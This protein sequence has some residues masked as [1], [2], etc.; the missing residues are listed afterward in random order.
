[1]AMALVGTGAAAAVFA[2][3]VLLNSIGSGKGSPRDYP[4]AT[5][6]AVLTTSPTLSTSRRKRRGSLRKVSSR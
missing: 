3:I 1:M 4:T 5:T 6:S 2:G